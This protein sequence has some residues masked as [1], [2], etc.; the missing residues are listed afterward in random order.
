[1]KIFSSKVIY[2]VSDCVCIRTLLQVGVVN[3]QEM[4]W[5]FFQDGHLPSRVKQ[6]LCCLRILLSYSFKKLH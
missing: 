5:Y 3:L 4:C 2:L 1:M 6:I